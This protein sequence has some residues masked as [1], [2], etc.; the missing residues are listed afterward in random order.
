MKTP[1]DLSASGN[2]YAYN[3]Y[4]SDLIKNQVNYKPQLI[5]AIIIPIIA[6]IIEIIQYLITTL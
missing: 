1:A 4:K 6:N 3:I 2:I 5:S